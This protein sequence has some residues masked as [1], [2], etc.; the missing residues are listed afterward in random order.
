MKI[1]IKSVII[2]GSDQQQINTPKQFQTSTLDLPTLKMMPQ[3]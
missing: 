2:V 3:V 1:L